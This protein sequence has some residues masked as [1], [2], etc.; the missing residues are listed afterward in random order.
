[1]AIIVSV[2]VWKFPLA[3]FNSLI[4]RLSLLSFGRARSRRKYLLILLFTGTVKRN[5]SLSVNA[6]RCG[7]VTRRGITITAKDA[8]NLE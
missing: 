6:L 1:M 4:Y 3:N 2:L 7:S 8:S 5:A